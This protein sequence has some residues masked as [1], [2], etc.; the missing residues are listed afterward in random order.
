M[1]AIILIWLIAGIIIAA[2]AVGR[3][4]SGVA[5]F[6]Y[7]MLFWPLALVHLLILPKTDARLAHEAKVAAGASGR[8][9]CPHCAEPIL[10]AAKICPHCKNDTGLLLVLT[11]DAGPH[12]GTTQQVR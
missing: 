6:L 9:P 2:A 8:V 3:G 7:G 1:V 4:R 12:A 5:W 10:P 11:T